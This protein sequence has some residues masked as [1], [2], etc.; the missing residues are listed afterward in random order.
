MFLAW[1]FMCKFVH[2]LQQQVRVIA[3]AGTSAWSSSWD[4]A[5]PL[6]FKIFFCIHRS[7]NRNGAFPRISFTR[8]FLWT[9]RNIFYYFLL[10]HVSIS[11]VLNAKINSTFEREDKSNG[12]P[13]LHQGFFFLSREFFLWTFRTIHYNLFLCRVSISRE[14]NAKKK[15]RRRRNSRGKTRAMKTHFC[16]IHLFSFSRI[17]LWTFRT[18]SSFQ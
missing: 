15:K 4:W 18:I 11:T 10:C 7:T 12:N 16:T 9:F 13:L 8:L 17:F 3:R 14:M 6:N 5:L 2:V 1:E